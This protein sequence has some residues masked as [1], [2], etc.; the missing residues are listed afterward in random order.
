MSKERN[1][2]ETA[3]LEPAVKEGL[4]VAE[5]GVVIWLE[6]PCRDVAGVLENISV[7]YLWLTCIK[8]IIH[9][10]L[11]LSGFIIMQ[12][13]CNVKVASLRVMF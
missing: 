5:E 13:I 12:F 8:I 4:R 10:I 9:D 1:L 2:S 3:A 7:E 6:F 11:V